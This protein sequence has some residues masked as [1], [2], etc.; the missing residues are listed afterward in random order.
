MANLSSRQIADRIGYGRA[1]ASDSAMARAFREARYQYLAEETRLRKNRT[2]ET[3]EPIR[4]PRDTS[5]GIENV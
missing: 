3:S 2:Q 5:R 1:C 4:K